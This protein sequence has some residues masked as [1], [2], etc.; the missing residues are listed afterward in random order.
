MKH[1]WEVR[2]WL[3]VF[4]LAM[5]SGYAIPQQVLDEWQVPILVFVVGPL[6]AWYARIVIKEIKMD[7]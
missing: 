7:G 6:L 2:A 3:V 4:G 1:E 5:S